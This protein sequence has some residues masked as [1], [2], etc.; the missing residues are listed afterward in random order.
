MTYVL[1]TWPESQ[2]LMEYD[3]FDQCILINDEKHLEIY[4]SSAYL[5]PEH[6]Y[7]ELSELLE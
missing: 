1:V 6:L 2:M 4:G 7:V 5:V 3:W